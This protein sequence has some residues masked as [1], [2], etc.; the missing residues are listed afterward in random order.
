TSASAATNTLLLRL[1]CAS[2][3]RPQPLHSCLPPQLALHAGSTARAGLQGQ[4]GQ[5]EQHG[6]TALDRRPI[7]AAG[8]RGRDGAPL[9]DEPG[10]SQS[11]SLCRRPVRQSTVLGNRTPT[12]T[13]AHRALKSAVAPGLEWTT[14]GWP[15]QI[16]P[17]PFRMW[18]PVPCYNIP[19][20]DLK[21]GAS[22]S[23]FQQN[24]KNVPSASSWHQPPN[25]N[26]NA[27]DARHQTSD[28]RSAAVT[29]LRR[30]ELTG[31]WE[32]EAPRC[33]RPHEQADETRSANMNETG[34]G[35]WARLTLD[36]ESKSQT[37]REKAMR[38]IVSG[39]CTLC[40]R[41]YMHMCV[42]TGVG[43]AA[44]ARPRPRSPST[45]GRA[46][47]DLTS[48]QA[49]ASEPRLLHSSSSGC[50]IRGHSYC[51][52]TAAIAPLPGR[53]I[54]TECWTHI[55]DPLITN[56]SLRCPDVQTHG[57]LASTR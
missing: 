51:A 29:P 50:E 7:H 38:N 8:A 21:P 14:A 37:Q 17:R 25:A 35:V 1:L 23:E 26:A 40:V 20:D 15:V 46:E 2:H 47:N 53:E 32:P 13:Q 18:I 54:R 52:S 55:A 22:D 19:L 34:A 24:S 57:L 49:R 9:S 39:L 11:S 41:M 44:D 31:S 27:V 10:R 16:P 6:S 43:I 36:S 45:S 12:W 56:I 48:T 42:G 5:L 3:L 4:K 33:P 30:W 28:R